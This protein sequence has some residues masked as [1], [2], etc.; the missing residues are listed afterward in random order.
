MQYI[1]ILFNLEMNCFQVVLNDLSHITT[2]LPAN[3]HHYFCCVGSAGGLATICFTVH[4][5]LPVSQPMGKQ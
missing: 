5:G 1:L 4:A 3:F 2:T